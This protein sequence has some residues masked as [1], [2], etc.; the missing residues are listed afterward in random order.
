[1]SPARFL[2]CDAV[3]MH[4]GPQTWI[5]IAQQDHTWL[6]LQRKVEPG[7]G[8]R[9]ASSQFDLDNTAHCALTLGE[10]GAS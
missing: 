1:M 2:D 4:D 8:V 5:A 10:S 9:R 6:R 7:Q 3:C